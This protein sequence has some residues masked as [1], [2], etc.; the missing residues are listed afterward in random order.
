[1]RRTKKQQIRKKVDLRL[2]IGRIISRAVRSLGPYMGDLHENGE[3]AAFARNEKCRT[4]RMSAHGGGTKQEFQRWLA[5]PTHMVT[6]PS[7]PI[8]PRAGPASTTSPARPSPP[9]PIVARTNQ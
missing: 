3:F 7:R 8:G 4:V 5:V 9:V 1:M 2:G 6:L